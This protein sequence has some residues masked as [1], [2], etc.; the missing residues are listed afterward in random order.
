MWRP[1]LRAVPTFSPTLEDELVTSA[2]RG[3][4]KAVGG[5]APSLSR[6][7]P[8]YMVGSKAYLWG[9]EEEAGCRVP[10][11]AAV[12]GG[13]ASPSGWRGADRDCVPFSRPPPYGY[14]CPLAAPPSEPLGRGQVPPSLGRLPC[15]PGGCAPGLSQTGS[16]L[17]RPLV[18]GME[19]RVCAFVKSEGV[20]LRRIRSGG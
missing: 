2:G 20:C 19:I 10:A 15:L 4:D 7:H 11:A 14:G 8:G 12:H 6:E 9:P 17:G 18:C 1:S 5:R 16:G 3:P 13:R